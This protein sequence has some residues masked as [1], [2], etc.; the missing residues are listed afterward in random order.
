ME[1]RRLKELGLFSEIQWRL[2]ESVT[3]LCKYIMAREENNQF[4]LKN[5]G[6]LRT[7]G[8]NLPQI[9]ST[10]TTKGGFSLLKQWG[11]Q[12]AFQD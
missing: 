10:W 7:N 6:S 2:K 5:I 12:T 9:N 4:Q 1:I 3:A 8:Y 11:S